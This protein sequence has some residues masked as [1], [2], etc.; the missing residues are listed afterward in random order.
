MAGRFRVGGEP[1]VSDENSEGRAYAL[2]S[3]LPREEEEMDADQASDAKVGHIFSS[4]GLLE[5]SN[6]SWFIRNFE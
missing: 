6:G 4:L 3:S 2:G 1:N 5:L